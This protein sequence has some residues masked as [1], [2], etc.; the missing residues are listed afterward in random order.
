[1]VTLLA[2]CG[3]SG[4]ASRWVEQKSRYCATPPRPW[5]RPA[6]RL[7]RPPSSPP[8]PHSDGEAVTWAARWGC[9]KRQKKGIGKLSPI[10]H[11]DVLTFVAPA[12]SCA[13]LTFSSPIISSFHLVQNQF[14]QLAASCSS[15]LARQS[16]ALLCLFLLIWLPRHT[17]CAPPTA[18]ATCSEK[19]SQLSRS[20]NTASNTQPLRHRPYKPTD[21]RIDLADITCCFFALLPISLLPQVRS[22][23]NFHTAGSLQQHRAHAARIFGQVPSCFPGFGL[24]GRQVRHYPAARLPQDCR[25]IRGCSSWAAVKVTM[26]SPSWKARRRATQSSKSLLGARLAVC[27]AVCISLC[28]SSPPLSRIA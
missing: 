23:Y 7:A 28:R 1:M 16:L 11:Y 24:L 20:A 15:L 9:R 25:K 14:P 27:T 2:P 6:F 18:S 26:A 5:P 21:G 17:S 10:R 13:S 19:P 3:A 12:N 4:S 8:K 22:L